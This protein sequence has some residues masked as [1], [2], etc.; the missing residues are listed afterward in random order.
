MNLTTET[1]DQVQ[2]FNRT[3]IINNI[4]ASVEMSVQTVSNME[5]LMDAIYVLYISAY[6]LVSSLTL[7]NLF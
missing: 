4:T 1:L 7:W 6:N 2:G 5:Y 3:I